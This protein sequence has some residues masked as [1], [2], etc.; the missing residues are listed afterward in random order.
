MLQKRPQDLKRVHN[1]VI[2]ARWELVKQ[3]EKTM[4][5]KIHDSDYKPGTLVLV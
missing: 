1:M 4:A 3:L 5:K 2:K